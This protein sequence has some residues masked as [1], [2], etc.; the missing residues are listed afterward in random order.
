MIFLGII[1]VYLLGFSII[2]FLHR[3]SETTSI[4]IDEFLGLAFLIGIGLET[5]FMFLF[6]L[7]NVKIN[8][9][10]LGMSSIA[11]IS[12]VGFYKREFFKNYLKNISKISFNSS[13][14]K[15]DIAW[16]VILL[17]II[18]FLLA[19]VLKSLFWPTTAYDSVAGYDLMGK[20][21]A[22]EGKIN[23]S[24]FKIGSA[25]PRGIYP[26]LIEG[27]FA[28]AYIFGSQSSKII[29]S[30]T[31][32]SLILVFYAFLRKYVTNLNAIFFTLLLIG[33]PEMFAYSSLS[34]S[35]IPSAAYASLGLLYLFMWFENQEKNL[36]Y[37]ASILLG[38][39]VWSR[40]DGIVFSI[41]G[42]VLMVFY[43]YKNKSW[44]EIAIYGSISFAPFILWTLYLK[45]KIGI[46]QDR[47]VNHLFWNANRFERL[48]L[49]IK[50]LVF[51]SQNYGLTFYLFLIALLLNIRDIHR[52]KFQLLILILISFV[53]YSAIFYQ[54]DEVKQGSLDSM[55]QYSYKRGLFYFIPLVLFYVAVSKPI[56]LFF[57][58]I[59]RHRIGKV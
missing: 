15:V 30:L 46:V 54:L 2:I 29:S 20:V 50:S 37:I 48:M 10:T 27:S 58:M 12:W 13:L 24:L 38:F 44:K 43:A 6:D 17:L 52:D 34:L 35:N 5:I 36:L 32:I 53:L 7:L 33:T 26:P 9:F 56:R 21:I 39:N 8:A 25:G 22:A 14:Q 18:I 28:Y 51:N 23:V 3:H 57:L 59:E 11:I 19:N 1:L 47:F 55:M 40:N 41:A 16:A 49:W 4:T 45:Y 31:Y 42:L